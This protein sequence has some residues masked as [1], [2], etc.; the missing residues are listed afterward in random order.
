V[1]RE[2]DLEHRQTVLILYLEPS[3]QILNNRKEVMRNMEGILAIVVGWII[4]AAIIS[5]FK[6]SGK[7]KGNHG[8]SSNLLTGN[9]ADKIVQDAA[10]KSKETELQKDIFASEESWEFYKDG[11]RKLN[12]SQQEYEIKYITKKLRAKREYKEKE[13]VRDKIDEAIRE[14]ELIYRA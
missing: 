9:Y 4:V 14:L 10:R 8:K 12:K 6:N 5:S 2:N 1:S 3:D 11:F 13:D 7:N